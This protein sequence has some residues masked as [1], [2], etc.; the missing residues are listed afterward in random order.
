M[1]GRIWI[2]LGVGAVVALGVGAGGYLLSAVIA[3][4]GAGYHAK[5]LC[6]G[7]FVA[8]RPEE[9]VIAVDLGRLWYVQGQVDRAA[10]T[11]T[12]SL[13][14]LGSATAVYRQGLGC[15]LAR[16][17]TAE[18]LR[19]EAP[20]VPAA[21]DTAGLPWPTG[22]LGAEP[23]PLPETDVQA[24]SAAVAAGF[25]NP[26]W[27]TR[28][29]VVVQSGSIV[30]ER[31][32]EGFDATTPLTGWSM[33][34]SVTSTLIG[35][36]AGEGHLD[37]SQP[38]G[39]PEW[40]DDARA[41]LTV[42]QLLRMSSGLDFSEVYGA[43]G[44]ATHML[45]VAPSTVAYAARSPLAHE[46]DAVWSY[47]SGT[48]NLLQRI[49]RRAVGEESYHAYPRTALFDRIGMR[50]AVIEPDAGGDF[51]GSSFMYATARDWARFGLLHVQDGTWEG[52]RLLPEG[53]VTY[54]TAPTEAAPRGE[55][56]AQWWLNAGSP[57]DSQDRRWPELPLDAYDASGFE[58]QNVLVV[59][60]RDVVIVRLGLSPDREVWNFGAFAAGVL[61]ALPEA[62]PVETRLKSE[63]AD[64]QPV[65]RAV[66]VHLGAQP[67]AEGAPSIVDQDWAELVRERQDLVDDPHGV[68]WTSHPSDRPVLLRLERGVV[69]APEPDWPTLALL[70][71]LA[72]ALDGR[73]TGD[74]GARY[75]A[76]PA[77]PT[78]VREVR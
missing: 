26:E 63:V 10:Q 69:A 21:R 23:S 50:S 44:D 19:A 58:G 9:Q 42:D 28:A 77:S 68:R 67:W 35:I 29:V 52:E 62:A 45:F 61:R 75:M 11:A 27:N 5:I 6:S 41:Q 16:G 73:V 57:D 40:S 54:A 3:P 4:K 17:T 33:T 53:W 20:S 1:N 36:A 18:A 71:E 64:V 65:D 8:Q 38:A 46:P 13:Y 66:Y 55:Y 24:L 70:L 76:D 12:S 15:T 30:A 48:S 37:I 22:D 39:L 60:S 59:P 72:D 2:G 49:L 7:V 25:A 34:K 74:L 56:G 31:Y 43:F 51:V 47:S 78:G 14:G 32:A